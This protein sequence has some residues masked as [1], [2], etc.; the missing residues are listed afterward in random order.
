LP[1]FING[2]KLE[3][4]MEKDPQ[5]TDLPPGWFEA[6][7]SPAGRL[8]RFEVDGVAVG[9]LREIYFEQGKNDCRGYIYPPGTS[10]GGEKEVCRGFNINDTIARVESEAEGYSTRYHQK[11]LHDLT[12]YWG[13]R[14]PHGRHGQ[15]EP[16]EVD[17]D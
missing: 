1:N 17:Q 16:A 13:R 11:P 15:D 14:Y 10:F 12:S 4:P 6:F 3:N 7:S 5:L 9:Y 2:Y 8:I